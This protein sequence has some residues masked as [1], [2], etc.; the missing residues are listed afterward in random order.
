MKPHFLMFFVSYPL[1]C[2]SILRIPLKKLPRESHRLSPHKA[3]NRW[4]R[5]EPENEKPVFVYDSAT[6]GMVG[7]GTPIQEI[8]LMFDT[9]G[10]ETWVFE[11]DCTIK[12]C[13]VT[14]TFKFSKSSTFNYLGVVKQK[15][16]KEFLLRGA[17]TTD[18]FIFGNFKM[19]N[20]TFIG[21]QDIDWTA[22]VERAH[23]ESVA[24]IIHLRPS[25]MTGSTDFLEKM[26]SE[27]IIEEKIFGIK[28]PSYKDNN[29]DGEITIGEWNRQYVNESAI[30][31]IPLT[32]GSSWEFHVQKLV[33][34]TFG[35]LEEGKAIVDTG[36]SLLVGPEEIVQKL[37]M[38]LNITLT[39]NP[40]TV[41]SFLSDY[42][43]FTVKCSDKLPYFNFLI[44]DNH[45]V[46][47][48]NDY[49]LP[50]PD[51]KDLCVFGF[52]SSKHIKTKAWR[53]GD[54][55]LSKFYMI[56]DGKNSRLSFNDYVL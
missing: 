23:T 16:Y 3:V 47:T 48:P 56:G 34:G 26:Y 46:L 20:V 19:D 4:K 37:F 33:Y 13:F 49:L 11:S 5:E 27:K 7:I 50:M 1:L 39:I 18:T 41:T 30:N 12:I 44:H 43:S 35:L 36:L 42:D 22:S 40:I 9:F 55:F 15:Y 17:A 6:Y 2:Q 8:P 51:N 38:A 52:A 24:G 54:V 25:A 31:W 29:V 28:V 53:L 10:N 32:S 45:Y 21:V 14:N